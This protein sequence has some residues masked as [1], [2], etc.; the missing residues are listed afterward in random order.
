MQQIAPGKY[1]MAHY[2]FATGLMNLGLMIPSMV[3]G[4]ISDHLGYQKFFVW[5]MIATIPSFFVAWFVPFKKTEELKE[6]TEN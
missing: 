4:F 3:S 2:A 5:V 6:H 1:K